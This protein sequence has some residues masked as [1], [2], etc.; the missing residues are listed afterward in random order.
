MSKDGMHTPRR[1]QGLSLVELMVAMVVALILLFG[2]VQIYLGT[3][4]TSRTQEGLSRVQEN[5]RF[6]IDTL[7]RDIRMAGHNGCARTSPPDVTVMANHADEDYILSGRHVIGVAEAASAGSDFWI[8]GEPGNLIDGQP[9]VRVTFSSGGEVSAE[10]DSFGGSAEFDID[11]NTIGLRQNDFAM[12][13]DC[14]TAHVF[15]ITNDIDDSDSTLNIAHSAG[16]GQTGGGNS[17]HQWDDSEQN[18]ND[19]AQV[20]R[21]YSYTYYIAKNPSGNRALY[22]RE[23][24]RSAGQPDVVEL[25]D[26]VEAMRLAYGQDTDEDR[27]VDQYVTA[28]DLSDTDWEDV[29]SVRLALLLRSDEVLSEAHTTSFDLLGQGTLTFTDDRRIYQQAAT[30]I[31]LRNRMP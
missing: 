15:E 24:M 4:A 17:P 18:Y 10:E 9:A 31:A 27:Q 16:G 1:Q 26:N 19:G 7:S 25:V 3:S 6:A 29:V 20:M 13:T 14:R 2:V 8:N 23:D 11:S 30:T 28:D 12:V 21:F 5:A 22:R